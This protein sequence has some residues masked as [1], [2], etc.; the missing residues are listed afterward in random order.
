MRVAVDGHMRS[1][2]D[3]GFSCSTEAAV[4]VIC[5]CALEI[6]LVVLSLPLTF[7]RVAIENKIKTQKQTN[8]IYFFAWRMALK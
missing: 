3:T 8:Q 7:K 5:N 1:F 4:L 2:R 6:N